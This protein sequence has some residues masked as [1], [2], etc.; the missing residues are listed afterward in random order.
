[1]KLLISLQ[2]LLLVVS[3]ASANYLD[4]VNWDGQCK[5]N[6]RQSPIDIPCEQYLNKCPPGKSYTVY[7]KNP[8]LTFGGS[9]KEDLTTISMD[10]SWVKFSN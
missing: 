5:N 4:Q 10:T 2:L 9:T 1:M 6:I 7:W 8:Q 3:A